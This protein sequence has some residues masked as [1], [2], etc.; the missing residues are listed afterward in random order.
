MI[1]Y[2]FYSLNLKGIFPL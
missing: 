2:L 1:K